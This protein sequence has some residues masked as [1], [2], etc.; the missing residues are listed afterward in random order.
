MHVEKKISNIINSDKTD[1]KEIVK[2]LNNQ[3]LFLPK[4]NVWTICTNMFNLNIKKM[5]KNIVNNYENI[6]INCLNSDHAK[7]FCNL[8]EKEYIIFNQLCEKFWPGT[9]K[10]I[11]KPSEIVPQSL[12]KNG[13]IQIGC[14]K[15]KI[16]RDLLKKT[17][18]PICSIKAKKSGDICLTSI[19]HILSY[20]KFED[21]NIYKTNYICKYGIDSTILKI[22]DSE[23]IVKQK[24]IISLNELS[25]FKLKYI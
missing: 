15:L 4:E 23:I 16:F 3:L 6:T 24:G 5:F 13:Y 19:D 18:D 7:L 22:I 1:L 11:V 10:I 12:I 8:N 17:N 2:F 20:Y 25:D 21:L 14:P 9:L